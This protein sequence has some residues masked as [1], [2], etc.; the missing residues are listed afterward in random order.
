[1]AVQQQRR[2]YVVF[3]NLGLAAV[4]VTVCA[5]GDYRWHWAVCF[6]LPPQDLCRDEIFKWCTESFGP[7]GRYRKWTW[8]LDDTILFVDQND[9]VQFQL[10]WG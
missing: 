3:L 6:S 7:Q 1:M 2:C 5:N 9:A 10:A 8:Y 4:T